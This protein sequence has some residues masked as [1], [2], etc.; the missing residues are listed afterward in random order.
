VD[1]KKQ[2]PPDERFCWF[3]G[4]DPAVTQAERYSDQVTA[5]IKGKPLV[6]A[7]GIATTGTAM[8]S[9]KR[10]VRFFVSYA[11]ANKVLVDALVKELSTHFASSARY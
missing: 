6:P 4:P 9:G 3:T 11:H 8:A 5:D 1:T 10:V 7:Q 2:N